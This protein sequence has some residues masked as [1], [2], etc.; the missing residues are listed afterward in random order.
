MS[1]CCVIIVSARIPLVFIKI[2][3]CTTY[4]KSGLS[5]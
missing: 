1:F 2:Q 5:R 4:S 3:I